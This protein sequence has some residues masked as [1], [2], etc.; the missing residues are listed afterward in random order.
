MHNKKR[1][2]SMFIVLLMMF[3]AF[4]AEPI[5]GNADEIISQGSMYHGPGTEYGVVENVDG[6]S[7]LQVYGEIDNWYIVYNANT[8]NV[9]CIAKDSA[10]TETAETVNNSSENT[11]L[12]YTNTER[13]KA[14]LKELSLDKDL[15]LAASKKASDMVKNNYF[16]HHSE[17]LGSPFELL[18]KCGI[19]FTKSA[20]N[21][22]GNTTSEGAFY[23][24]MN[25]E[26]QRNNILS[27]E[28]TRMG[29][30]VCN[31]PVYGQIYVQIFAN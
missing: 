8:G 30:G 1:I 20:E 12:N 24:W 9:G 17:T 22:A 27:S 19:T 15:C 26:A 29:I 16:S 6:N 3:C 13:K 10:S 2:L 25:S 31:S 14:G 11:I 7:D 28:Y 21:L 18:K 23:A 4:S 5:S